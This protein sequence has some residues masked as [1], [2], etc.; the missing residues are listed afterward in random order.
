[1]SLG[2]AGIAGSSLVGRARR[3]K[4]VLIGMIQSAGDTVVLAVPVDGL[5]AVLPNED[6]YES[7]RDRAA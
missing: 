4:H 7:A 6:I 3:T 5:R 2:L 1:M